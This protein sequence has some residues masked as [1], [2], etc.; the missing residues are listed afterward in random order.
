VPSHLTGPPNPDEHNPYY[1]KYLS[2]VPEPD[3]PTAMEVQT[4]AGLRFL[5]SIP[6]EKAGYRYAPDKWSVR[7][8]VGHVV[9]TE[10]IFGFRALAFARGERAEIPGMDQDEYVRQANFDELTLPDLIAQ[11]EAVR[12]ASATFY[13]SLSAEAW[14]RRG[15]AN[16]NMISVRALAYIVIG[17]ERHHWGVLRASYL[18]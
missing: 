3:F 18:A 14:L 4:S 5:R 13:G 16:G 8:V 10:R 12:R 11:F 1:G 6:P 15:T 9:D 17:H 2:L 7:E